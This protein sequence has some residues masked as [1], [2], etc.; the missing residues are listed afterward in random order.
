[1]SDR[2]KGKDNHVKTADANTGGSRR[3]CA[4]DSRAT[5]QSGKAAEV[6]C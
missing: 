4:V 5:R 1:M 6:S 3:V 2:V